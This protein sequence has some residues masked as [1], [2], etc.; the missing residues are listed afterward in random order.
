MTWKNFASVAVLCLLVSPVFADPQLNVVPGGIQGGNFVWDVSITPDLA[1]PFDGDTPVAF[2]LG[3]RLTDAPLISATNINPGEFDSPNPGNVI[4]GWETLTD[5]DPGPGMNL[6]PVGLQTNTGT[7]EIFAAFGSIVFATPGPKPF[8][9]I[10]AQ[11][12]ANGGPS[13]SSTIQWLGAYAVGHGRIAQI[14]GI[15][16]ENFDLYAGTATQAIPEPA[17]GALLVFG[18]VAMLLGLGRRHR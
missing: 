10:V 11:G 16:G 4:F 9:Q 13:L 8:L 3:F 7:G 1:L 15:T 12:P 18:A 5:L 6:K 14:V 17:S 2:E